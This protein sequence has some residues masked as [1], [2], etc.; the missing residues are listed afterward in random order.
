MFFEPTEREPRAVL[1]RHVQLHHRL[2]LAIV[3]NQ[4]DLLDVRVDQVDL[5]AKPDIGIQ[6][7]AADCIEITDTEPQLAQNV[8]PVAPRQRPNPMFTG[9]TMHD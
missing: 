1:Q 6:V 4:P 5:R 2:K 8:T 3:T 9:R 7:P